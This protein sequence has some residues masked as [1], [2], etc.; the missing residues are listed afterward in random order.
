MEL[1]IKKMG[2]NGEGIGYW[3]RRPVFVPGALPGER[4]AAEIRRDAGSYAVAQ[5]ERILTASPQRVAAPCG[6]QPVCGGCPLMILDYPGQLAAKRELLQEALRKYAGLAVDVPPVIGADPVLGY[7]NKLVMPV[8]GRPNDLQTAFFQPGTNHPVAIRRCLIHEPWLEV[9]RR[10]VL[11][12]LNGLSVAPYDRNRRTGLRFLAIRGFAGR[13]QITLVSGRDG[14]PP[15]TGAV[16]SAIPGVASVFTGVN[17]R[18]QPRPILPEALTRLAGQ[19]TLPLT[20]NGLDLSIAPQSFFQLNTAQA[21]RLYALIGEKAGRLV[22]EKGTV[23]EVYCGIGA[24]GLSL[25]QS[26]FSLIGVDWSMANIDDARR[27]AERNGIADAEWL[28]ADAAA[29][30]GPVMAR[31]HVDLVVVDPPR[32]G[33]QEAMIKALLASPP[34]ALLYVSCNPAT[35]AKDLDRLKQRYHLV[36]VDA[37]DMFPNTPLVETVVCLHR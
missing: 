17:D 27:N 19:K 11:E 29:A 20:V 18:R 7:R 8:T 4:V 3:Q 21:A 2:I 28:C 26:G 35:L 10:Q 14:L 22:G 6:R 12:V 24:I 32:S 31:R 34:E 37:L 33:L 1:T 9:I 13:A 15:E 36:S 16:L 23:L 25:A 30:V 5:C